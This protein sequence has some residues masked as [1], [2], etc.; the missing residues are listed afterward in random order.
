MRK[1]T[2]KA[3]KTLPA[4]RNPV[5]CFK[6]G[7]VKEVAEDM[8]NY[9]QETF[10]ENFTEPGENNEDG[11][12]GAEGSEVGQVPAEEEDPLEDM[13]PA[14]QEPAEELEDNS[15]GKSEPVEEVNP[16]ANNSAP[17]RTNKRK[18]GS[19]VPKTKLFGKGS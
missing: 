13:E 1:L 6:A 14:I 9:L 8:A 18:R 7:E 5:L 15:L 4:Y 10:P 17:K 19:G 16:V 2:F 3:T 12:E 11:L